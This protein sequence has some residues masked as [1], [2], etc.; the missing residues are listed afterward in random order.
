MTSYYVYIM[1]NYTNTTLYIGVTN[2][3]SKNFE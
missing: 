3:L 2:D 1:S